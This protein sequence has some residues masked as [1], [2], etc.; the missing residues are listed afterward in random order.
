MKK[1]IVSAASVLMLLLLHQSL[2]FASIS[3]FTG[4]WTNTDPDTRGITKLQITKDGSGIRLH[5]W[6]KCHPEDCD[7]GEVV[8]HPY[9]PNVSSDMM[10]RTRAV[11]AVFTEGFK[12]TVIVVRSAGKN[13][14]QANAFTRF[15]DGSNRSNYT[16]FYRF[17]RQ[18]QVL[19]VTPMPIPMPLPQPV[20]QL[21]ED[22][23][24]FN[25]A[26]TTVKNVNGSWK[27]VDGN[28]WMFDFGN[29][30]SEAYKALRVIKHYKLNQSCFVGRPDPS[31]QYML[32]S[33]NA[34]KGPMPG[35]DCISFNPSTIE[36]KEINGRW[37]IVDGNH[38][39]FDFG[40]KEDEARTAYAVIKKYG[41]T[42]SCFVGRP[43]PS[44]QYL[45]K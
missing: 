30:R 42:R 45:R 5:A 39:M 43:D 33:G 22:C 41:F 44:F 13:K 6:G 28:H 36:V 17:N 10:Q 15:T 34:P 11:T 35:E 9:A 23:I 38:W 16:S 20:P 18:F 2:G 21:K 32:T 8:A 31:F 29:K 7:W 12:E 3:Q 19:P 25:P 40:N 4:T 37:K 14:L 27:I 1:I 26:T 24:S